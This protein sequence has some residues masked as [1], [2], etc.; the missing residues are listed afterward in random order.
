[1]TRV[2]VATPADYEDWR[3]LAREVEGL[4]GPMADKPSFGE[5]LRRAIDEGVALCAEADDPGADGTFRG[6]IVFCRE[7]NEIR[8]LAVQA[9]YRG[10]GVG[11]A[12]V[13]AAIERLDPG[14]PITV[15]TFDS[16]VAEGAA[17]RAL[18]ESFGFTDCAPAGR[19][20]AGIQT[21]VMS[22]TSP[23]TSSQARRT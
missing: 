7:A 19:N 21:V 13:K 17:A 1:M 20:P 4:F 18:Y 2:R 11:A 6:G 23:R 8:W 22:L 9:A 12:L 15:T 14:K 10:R 3:R 16:S 5:G